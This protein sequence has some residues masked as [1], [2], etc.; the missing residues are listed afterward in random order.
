MK[1]P[2]KGVYQN[3]GME[4]KSEG[5]IIATLLPFQLTHLLKTHKDYPVKSCPQMI[6]K[7]EISVLPYLWGLEDRT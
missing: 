2:R 5:K 3:L 6:F 7:L 4:Q 1:I